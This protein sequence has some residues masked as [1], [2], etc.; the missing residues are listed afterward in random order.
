MNHA[1]KFTARQ[2]QR[3]SLSASLGKAVTRTRIRDRNGRN[4]NSES[5]RLPTARP[6]DTST[7]VTV[8]VV[9]AGPGEHGGRAALGRP[10]DSG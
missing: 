2:C 6:G 3:A 4:S 1:S 10:G 9:D 5:E 8:T 7:T